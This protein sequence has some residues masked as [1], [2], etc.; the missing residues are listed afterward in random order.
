MT[1]S[2][3]TLVSATP[4]TANPV[5]DRFGA[6]RDWADVGLVD[7]DTGRPGWNPSRGYRPIHY[8]VDYSVRPDAHLR[9]PFRMMTWGLIAA[10]PA[11]GSMVLNIP[12]RADRS[13]NDSAILYWLHCTPT[14]PQWCAH[15]TGEVVTENAGHGVGAPHLHR[16]LAVTLDLYEALVDAG[17]LRTDVVT[18]DEFTQRA[19]D[20]NMPVDAVL[21]RI[22]QQIDGDGIIR[23]ERD[24]IVMQR[25]R[26]ADKLSRHSRVGRDITVLVNPIAVIGGGRE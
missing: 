4:E 9:A 1:D 14:K 15:T 19:R 20:R 12:L 24:A 2:V 26:N 11:I 18:E 8:G 5:T 17:L 13:P 3:A 16:E 25:F 21:R 6:F 10:D 23:I 22:R 7:P